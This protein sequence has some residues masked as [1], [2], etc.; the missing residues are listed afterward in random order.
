MSPFYLLKLLLFRKFR[1][2]SMNKDDA[3]CSD[4]FCFF[5]FCLCLSSYFLFLIY[6]SFVGRSSNYSEYIEGPFNADLFYE[7]WDLSSCIFYF[8]SFVQIKIFTVGLWWGKKLCCNYL[9]L[10]AFVFF[11]VSSPK[12]YEPES[13]ESLD[14]DLFLRKDYS[15]YML[16][17]RYPPKIIYFIILI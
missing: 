5:Y 11:G 14:Y 4:I 15:W 12:T 17:K 13:P 2:Y 1:F 6:S 3:I 9:L 16:R 7:F 10:T 8:G